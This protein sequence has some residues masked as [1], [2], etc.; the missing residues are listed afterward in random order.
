MRVLL[1]AIVVALAAVVATAP[2]AS[3]QQG[4]ARYVVELDPGQGAAG[5]RRAELEQRTRALGGRVVA[6]LEH[7]LNGAIVELSPQRAHRLW[8]RGL[9]GLFADTVISTQAV[10]PAA[11]WNLDRLDQPAL[12]LDG[13]YAYP[14]DMTGAGVTAYVIDT[15]IRDTHEEFEGRARRG[16]DALFGSG[17][18]CNGHGTHVAGTIG[19]R[20]YGVAKGVDL[21]GVRVIDCNGYTLATAVLLG[22]EWVIADHR[23]GE[24][25]VANM[26]FGGIAN[27]ILDSA[28]RRL[29]DDGVTT[30]VAAGN[31]SV[32]AC[33]T[34]P[35][36]I[37]A[38][39]TVAAADVADR[40]ASFSDHGRCV[41][42]TAPG[43]AVTSADE[44]SDTG[45][46][47]YSG[48]SMA[49]PHVAGVAARLLQRAPAA[50]PGEIQDAITAGASPGV[51]TAVPR[52]CLWYPWG[53]AMRTPNRVLQAA[54][55]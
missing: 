53:C 38:V 19:G 49:S 14:D 10:Q 47:T 45:L 7:A 30:A 48:T 55:A 42:V 52:T 13:T 12:P 25:A 43:V 51:L 50:T 40:F 3:A 29:V 24:P 26:S 27:G 46:V 5:D 16:F 31:W 34:S 44:D 28:V 15:G 1:V 6:T 37:G 23:A 35:A 39:I 32:D 20:T 4:T 41:D 8:L 33:W 36:R 22:I 21:V 54:G 18:D 2:P 9:R 17:R 11:P